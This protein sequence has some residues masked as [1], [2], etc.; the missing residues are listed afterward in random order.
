MITLI[1]PDTWYEINR[2]YQNERQQNRQN[3]PI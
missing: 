3:R 2:D 1:H